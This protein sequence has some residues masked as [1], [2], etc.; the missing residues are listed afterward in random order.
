MP[1][2]Y[3]SAIFPSWISELQQ[4]DAS[5]SAQ[6]PSSHTQPELSPPTC[7][8]FEGD[9][10]LSPEK[11]EKRIGYILNFALNK[12]LLQRRVVNGGHPFINQS[13]CT[14]TR[15]GPSIA[16]HNVKWLPWSKPQQTYFTFPFCSLLWQV[17]GMFSLIRNKSVVACN[18]KMP[19]QK[20]RAK[21]NR[22][23]QTV[24]WPSQLPPSKLA[25]NKPGCMVGIVFSTKYNQ[26]PNTREAW[27]NASNALS[28]TD[29]P[30]IWPCFLRW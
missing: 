12:W 13:G 14:N 1:T 23:K 8:C 27:Q 2:S 9:R 28:A 24:T 30:L 11:S 4:L 25:P 26:T 22:V 3:P 16:T 29:S 6:T 17:L 20:R 21:T 15:D 7:Q 18:R 5:T 10:S 19:V